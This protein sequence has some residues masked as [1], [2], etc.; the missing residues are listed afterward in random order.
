MTTETLAVM[1]ATL[2]NG[3]ICPTTS[4]KVIHTILT[5]LLPSLLGKGSLS[6]TCHLFN[7][8]V[9]SPSKRVTEAP[10]ANP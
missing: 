4:E 2:A 10:W 7:L 6:V 3:G 1:G 9:G 8:K 5:N